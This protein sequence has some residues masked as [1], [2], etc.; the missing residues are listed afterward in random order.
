LF[1]FMPVGRDL[2]K[3]YTSDVVSHYF[4]KSFPGHA[5][6]L[7]FIAREPHQGSFRDLERLEFFAIGTNSEYNVCPFNGLC[8]GPAFDFVL[9][10]DPPAV[11]NARLS[12]CFQESFTF[13]IFTSGQYLEPHRRPRHAAVEQPPGAIELFGIR[14]D[15]N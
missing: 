8:G 3:L 15:V 12:S 11:S 4:I 14:V 13:W 9:H 10:S 1:Y 2:T 5:V 6:S 7:G